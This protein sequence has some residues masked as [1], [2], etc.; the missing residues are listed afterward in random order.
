MERQ[1]AL[2]KWWEAS[3]SRSQMR[4]HIVEGYGA[5]GKVIHGADDADGFGSL[6]VAEDF[7]SLADFR[8]G[9]VDVVV[10]HSLYVLVV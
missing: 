2:M 4:L 8:D 5:R 3:R 1:S 10:N 7:A 6:G 9:T